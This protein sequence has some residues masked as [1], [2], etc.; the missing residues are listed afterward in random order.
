MDLFDDDEELAP[1]DPDDYD[2]LAE[3]VAA[4]IIGEYDR[5]LSVMAALEKSIP[6]VA[7]TL[8]DLGAFMLGFMNSELTPAVESTMPYYDAGCAVR[9]H[10]YEEEEV[11]YDE[12]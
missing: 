9:S 6:R 2:S 12:E 5:G 10:L 3:A 11:E 8:E 4:T 1:V 7:M